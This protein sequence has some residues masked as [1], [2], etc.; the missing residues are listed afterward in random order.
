MDKRISTLIFIY[1]VY[2]LIA[3]SMLFFAPAQ[4]FLTGMFFGLTGIG[5]F[6]MFFFLWVLQRRN[7]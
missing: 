6:L 4:K 2:L 1:V 5:L 3:L 7:N